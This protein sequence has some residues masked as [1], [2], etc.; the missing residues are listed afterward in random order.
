MILELQPVQSRQLRCFARDRIPS[1]YAAEVLFPRNKVGESVPYIRL[2]KE[3][4]RLKSDLVYEDPYELVS[5]HSR[6]L[7]CQSFKIDECFDFVTPN[8]S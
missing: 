5:S 3:R 8:L 7:P 1:S 4:L 6:Y 2:S